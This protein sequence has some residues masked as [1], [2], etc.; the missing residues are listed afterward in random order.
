[1]SYKTY[2]L[3]RDFLINN[4]ACAAGLRAFDAIAKNGEITLSNSQDEM[5]ELVSGLWDVNDEYVNVV[6]FVSWVGSQTG[7]KMLVNMC[8]TYY[9]ELQLAGCYLSDLIVFKD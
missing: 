2:T 3:T 1:V 8:S 6:I 5:N 4:G 7:N 9:D